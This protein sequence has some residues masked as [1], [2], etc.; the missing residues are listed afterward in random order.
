MSLGA[1]LPIVNRAF[2]SFP[3]RV[4]NV[5]NHLSV[6]LDPLS[7][8]RLVVPAI[9]CPVELLVLVLQTLSLRPTKWWLSDRLSVRIV[10]F[11]VQVELTPEK[12]NLLSA[13]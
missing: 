9:L 4:P 7:Q 5:F 2:Q 10:H 12:K 3:T 8:K 11:V 6:L 1:L 13:V